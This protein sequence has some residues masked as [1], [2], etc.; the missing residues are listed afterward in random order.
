MTVKE[1]KMII[2]KDVAVGR[3]H[4][5]LQRLRDNVDD[6]VS[7]DVYFS[8]VNVYARVSAPW[9]M[10]CPGIEGIDLILRDRTIGD[11]SYIVREYN[12][13]HWSEEEK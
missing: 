6:E 4:A 10:S 11:L 12:E 1:V 8:E 2:R 9:G 5:L 13:L 7:V 3:L